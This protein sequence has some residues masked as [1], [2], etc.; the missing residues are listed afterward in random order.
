[1]PSGSVDGTSQP[2]RVA[3]M[4]GPASAG[5]GTGQPFRVAAVVGPA[6]AGGGAGQPS[7]VAAVAGPVGAG[8]GAG[9]PFRVAAGMVGRQRLRRGKMPPPPETASAMGSWRNRA[10]RRNTAI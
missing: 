6:S 4:A 5:G 8:G 7:Q 1:M 9:Q 10:T 2:F 3:A